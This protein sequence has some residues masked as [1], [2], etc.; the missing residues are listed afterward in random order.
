MTYRV[1]YSNGVVIYKKFS[2]DR[3]AEFWK[4]DEGDHVVRFDK[5]V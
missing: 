2:S 3:E 4:H 5:V 1:E